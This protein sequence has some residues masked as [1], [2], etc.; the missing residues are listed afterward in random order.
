MPPDDEIP[1]F[2]P[3]HMPH[4]IGIIMDGNG[5]WAVERGLARFRGHEVGVASVRE[6][7]RACND[8]GVQV[9]TIYAFSSENWKRPRLEVNALMRLL[10]RYLRAE[11]DDMHAEHVCVRFIGDLDA[12]PHTVRREVDLS[13]ELT[14]HNT[15]LLLNIAL[16]YGGRDEL[17]RACRSLAHDVRAGTLA[18]E[19]IDAEAISARLDTAGQ[20]DPDLIIRTAG[21]MR[22]SNFLLWQASYAEYYCTETL[23][24]DFRKKALAEAIVEFQRRTRKYGGVNT[25][26]KKKKGK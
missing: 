21:E 10:R 25:S 22:L 15:G 13:I 5:R 20:P 1:V 17:V 7:I 19:A 2:D 9:L 18:L 23:W 11:R 26:L 14:R 16:S 24:P 8:W 4:H 6:I 3:E 12:L